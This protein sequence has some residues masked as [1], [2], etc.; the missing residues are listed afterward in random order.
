MPKIVACMRACDFIDGKIQKGIDCVSE[1]LIQAIFYSYEKYKEAA[2]KELPKS[3]GAGIAGPQNPKELWVSL[4]SEMENLAEALG[5]RFVLGLSKGLAKVVQE[6]MPYP[7]SRQLIK[8]PEIIP[9][10]GKLIDLFPGSACPSADE[11]LRPKSRLQQREEIDSDSDSDEEEKPAKEKAIEQIKQIEASLACIETDSTSA[12][13]IALYEK[14][15]WQTESLQKSIPLFAFYLTNLFWNSF[16]A[17]KARNKEGLV[18]MI[19]WLGGS[20]TSVMQLRKSASFSDVAR[21]SCY[22][23]ERFSLTILKVCFISSFLLL[24]C[25]FSN[26]KEIDHIQRC[27]LI[28]WNTGISGVISALITIISLSVL[29]R[30]YEKKINI[31]KQI[32]ALQKKNLESRLSIVKATPDKP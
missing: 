6:K 22:T 12:R 29:K 15:L 11:S 26:F 23:P 1:E 30:G 32:I 25:F 21:F 28:I 2:L 14:F 7:I 27:D 4:K 5:H 18:S 10:G 16:E 3:R 24:C 19:F 9:D 13:R 8:A 17:E 31:E 20:T